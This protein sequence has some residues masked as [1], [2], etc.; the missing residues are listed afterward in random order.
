MACP[1]APGSSCTGDDGY[2]D[3][4]AGA[5]VISQVRYRFGSESPPG[6]AAV[7]LLVAHVFTISIDEP[8][9]RLLKRVR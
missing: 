6:F 5:T 9:L 2:A 8:C 7:V 3:L 1:P 4:N